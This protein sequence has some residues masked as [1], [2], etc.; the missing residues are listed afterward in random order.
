VAVWLHCHRSCKESPEALPRAYQQAPTAMWRALAA[1][2]LLFWAL[3]LKDGPVPKP[4]KK[5]IACLANVVY[6]EAR[7]EPLVGQRAV[8]DTVYNRMLQS[9]SSACEVVK[10]KRQFSWVG[11]KA[12][13]SHE[14]AHPW[15]VKAA[16]QPRI[17]KDRN[18]RYFYSGETPGWARG[19]KCRKIGRHNFCKERK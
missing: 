16:T 8:L 17:L 2:V 13:L 7:G 12:W 10:A 1:F 11:K 4:D 5:E 18:F 9:G 6:H 3:P 14:D 15:F 19:M